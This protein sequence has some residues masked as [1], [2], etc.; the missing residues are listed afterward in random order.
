M[1]VMITVKYWTQS[2]A[3]KKVLYIYKYI[4]SFSSTLITEKQQF[5]KASMTN[6]L[7]TSKTIFEPLGSKVVS[8]NEYKLH[9]LC[10][11]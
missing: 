9:I 3:Y 6:R 11:L 4:D 8:V 2:L 7:F 5:K 1:S 10:Y